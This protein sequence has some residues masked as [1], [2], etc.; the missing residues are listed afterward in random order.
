MEQNPYAAPTTRVADNES[1]EPTEPASRGQRFINL[2]ID[3]V[4]Y[5]ALAIV[6]GIVVGI[7][8]P[9]FIESSSPSATPS[10]ASS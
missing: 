8:Y 2:L 7:V 6:V 10:L 5:F 3:L 9:P 1:P 4:G